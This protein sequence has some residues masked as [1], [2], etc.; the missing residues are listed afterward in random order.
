MYFFRSLPLPDGI[1]GQ[2]FLSSM[3]GRDEDMAS[4]FEKAAIHNLDIILSLA[5]IE[6]IKSKSSG[7]A[8]AISE[9]A[10]PYKWKSFHIPDF[11]IP[12]DE[13]AFKAFI[14][15]EVLEL[16][17]GKKLLLHCGAGVGRTGMVAACILIAFGWSYNLADKAVRESGSGA[18]TSEQQ[19]LVQRFSQI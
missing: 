3:P 11:G 6:E 12:V 8:K 13:L 19:S 1:S 2:L 10:I 17:A 9:K 16:K 18:E 15:D 5:D 14:L 4:F 7:Y